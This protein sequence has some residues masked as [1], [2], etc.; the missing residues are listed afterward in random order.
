[1]GSHVFLLTNV[2]GGPVARCPVAGP[3]IVVGGEGRSSQQL[4]FSHPVTIRCQRRGR[5]VQ[6]HEHSSVEACDTGTVLALLL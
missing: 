6:T 3:F 5:N 1:M 2:S 4:Q